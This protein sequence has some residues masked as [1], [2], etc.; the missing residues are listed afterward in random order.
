MIEPGRPDAHVAR[1]LQIN[2][3]PLGSWV[4]AWHEANP[5]GFSP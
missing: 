3:G 5:D 2:E 4:H 1:E